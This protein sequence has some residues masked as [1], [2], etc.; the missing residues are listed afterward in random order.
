[1]K[2]YYQ[3]QGIKKWVSNIKNDFLIL[4][5]HFFLVFNI[6]KYHWFI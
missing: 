3:K 2:S 4:G 6:R 5:I 1:M